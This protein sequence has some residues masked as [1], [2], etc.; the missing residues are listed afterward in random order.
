MKFISIVIPFYTQD[1]KIYF[2]NQVRQS[3]DELNSKLEFPGGK[4]EADESPKQAAMREVEE[5]VGVKLMDSMLDLFKIYEFPEGLNIY[6]YL[7]EDQNKA[8]FSK[9]Y[10]EA[11]F[12]LLV[13]DRIMPNNMVIFEEVSKYLQDVRREG[14]P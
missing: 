4:I 14:S 10:H 6:V 7:F 13:K 2:W 5:E 12:Y 8:F 1:H 11:S 3:S 9:G